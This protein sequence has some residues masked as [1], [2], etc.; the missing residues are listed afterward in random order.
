MYYRKYH[1]FLI[2]KQKYAYCN[3][4]NILLRDRL[5]NLIVKRLIYFAVYVRQ[6]ISF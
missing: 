3:V 1:S 2:P 6:L 4:K 5:L